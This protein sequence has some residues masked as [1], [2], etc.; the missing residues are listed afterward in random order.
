[1]KEP[2]T[3]SATELNRWSGKILHR[4]HVAG[5]HILVER[6]G[7]PLAVIVPIVDYNARMKDGESTKDQTKR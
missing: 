3:I 4:V 2:T 7:Y 1:M 5:E 6:D